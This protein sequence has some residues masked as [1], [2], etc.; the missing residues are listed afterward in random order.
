MKQR[1]FCDWHSV[2]EILKFYRS[3]GTVVKLLETFKEY[4]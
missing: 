1:E 2:R 3:H 4:S